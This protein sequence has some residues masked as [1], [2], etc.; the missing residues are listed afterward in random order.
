MAKRSNTS[1]AIDPARLA[2]FESLATS[3]AEEMGATLRHTALS[4]N[5]KERA[6]YSCAVFDAGGRLLAQA[7]HIPVHLGAMPESVGAVREL[8]PWSPGDIAILNDPFRG[9]THLPDVTMVS[10]VFRPGREGRGS[11]V[12]YV[13]SRAHQADIGGMAPGSMPVAQELVQEGFI[14]PPVRLYRAGALVPET[15]ALFLRNVRTPVERQGD[16]DAQVAAQRVGERRLAAL[17]ERFG[18]AGFRRASA[19]LLDA[20]ERAALAGMAAIPPGTYAFED[21]LDDDGASD[22]PVPIRLRLT[23]SAAGWDLDFT[24]SAGQRPG[25]IN[26]VAAVTRSASYYVLRC[27]LPPQAPTNAGLFRPLRFTL[28]ARSVV[29]AAPPAAVA[30]GNVETSQRIVDVV[31]GAIAQALPDRMPAASAGTM[32]NVAAGG[33]DPRSGESWAYYETS[34]GGL[35]GGPLGPGIEAVQ[36]HMTNTLNT[37]AEA[38]EIAYPLRVLENSVR[39]GSGGAGRHRGGDGLVRRTQFLGPATV[40][41]IGERRR[42][43]PWGAAGGA[44]GTPGRNRLERAG[45]P[46]RALPGKTTFTVEAGDIICMETPGGGGWG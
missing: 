14:I 11:L 26:A 5:I 28:P 9:G 46:D 29:N 1:G 19:A 15:L 7:A 30:A 20:G 33:I 27:L 31:W 21:A 18:A 2:V 17:A 41:L 37:P 45:R 16:V 35:G 8:A 6:D 4:P 23:T 43:G 44:D 24:G 32:N 10:P 42:R 22:E 40:T 38:L 39:R 34:G 13:A 36:S 25:S 12:G 3:I